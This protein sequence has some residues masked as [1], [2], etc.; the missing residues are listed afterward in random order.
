MYLCTLVEHV[1]VCSMVAWRPGA[2]RGRRRRRRPGARRP[3]RRSLGRSVRLVSCRR[4]S[5]RPPCDK[6]CINNGRTYAI[7]WDGTHSMRY[8]YCL[9][10][11][12]ELLMLLLTW[13]YQGPIFI[14][15]LFSSLFSQDKLTYIVHHI[16]FK[17]LLLFLEPFY[18]WYKF[19]N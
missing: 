13:M 6:Y 9:G 14:D 19:W 15:I 5:S 12:G 11:R 2:G 7:S 18:N 3:R 1:T 16:F 4:V 10:N 17:F 8:F